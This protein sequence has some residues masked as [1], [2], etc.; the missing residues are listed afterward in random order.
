MNEGG[1]DCWL[2]GSGSCLLGK[3]PTMLARLHKNRDDKEEEE[4]EEEEEEVM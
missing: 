4:E 3:S 2:A 1:M